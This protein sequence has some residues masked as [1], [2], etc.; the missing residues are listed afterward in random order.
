[1]IT[2]VIHNIG[3]IVTWTFNFNKLAG[4]PNVY[5]ITIA[6]PLGMTYV[7]ASFLSSKVGAT[8]VDP[9]ISMGSMTAPE[10][11]SI[12]LKFQVNAILPTYTFVA[13]GNTDTTVLNNVDTAIVTYEDCPPLAGAIDDPHACLCYNM[14]AN[15][16]PCSHCTTEW[17]IE[18]GSEVNVVVN[19]H[20]VTT[21]I[22]NVSLID[23][24][25]P[26]SLQY[27]IWC[28]CGVSEYQVSGPAT[29]TWD[30]LFLNSGAKIYEVEDFVANPGDSIFV[31]ANTP[32]ATDDIEVEVNSVNLTAAE[33]TLLGTTVTLVTPLSLAVNGA[34]PINVR[35]TYFR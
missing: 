14:A 22:G 3:D 21:G 20:D 26:G 35:I 6:T 30:P 24:Y 29:V 27:Y 34:G 8:F 5:T 19:T 25:L 16:T 13:T 10:T 1:M 7:P 32:L 18:P 9:T 12:E 11:A 23:G 2:P 31:L 15:D 33:Y 17:R 28:I 4:P